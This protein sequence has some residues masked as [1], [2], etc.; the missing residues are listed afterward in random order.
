MDFIRNQISWGSHMSFVVGL[1]ADIVMDMFS[2]PF[3]M[4]VHYWSRIALGPFVTLR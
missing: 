4:I 2:L 3:S 1:L